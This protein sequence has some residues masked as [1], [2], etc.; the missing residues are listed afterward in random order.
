MQFSVSE[1]VRKILAIVSAQA[2]RPAFANAPA[3]Q[4]I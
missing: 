3:W 2:T 4:A 1:F